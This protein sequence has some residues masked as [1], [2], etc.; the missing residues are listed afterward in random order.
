MS[1]DAVSVE[2]IIHSAKQDITK[3][4]DPEGK[5]WAWNRKLVEALRGRGVDAVLFGSPHY[6][7][8]NRR[9]GQGRGHWITII[10]A[11]IGWMAI[12]LSSGQMQ[13]MEVEKEW[14][15]DSLEELCEEV[16]GDLPRFIYYSEALE[17]EF[18]QTAER[19]RERP[20]E[21]RPRRG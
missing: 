8:Q 18:V 14:R 12:D 17:S 20:H 1:Q 3:G 2:E 7:F 9:G 19:E 6:E 11:E 4:Q 15:A 5:C 16:R 10:K 21:L 13:G